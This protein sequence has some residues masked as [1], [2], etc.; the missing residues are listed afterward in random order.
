[1]AK[2][3]FAGRLAMREEGPMWV[4]YYALPDTMS[5][6]VFLGSI[7]LRFVQ[8]KERKDTFMELMREAVSDIIEEQTG[9]RPVWP[10]PHGHPAP[11]SERGG[12][13]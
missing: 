2:V 5:G 10:E 12:N 11:E 6:A 1:M 4:A 13:A 8:D 7:A 9:S 3:E